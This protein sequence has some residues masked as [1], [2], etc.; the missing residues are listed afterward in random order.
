MKAFN[1]DYYL[2]EHFLDLKERYKINTVIETGTFEGDTTLWLS[3]NFFQVFTIENNRMYYDNAVQRF[4]GSNIQQ[5]FGDSAQQLI[6]ILAMLQEQFILFLDAHWGKN[7]LLGELKAVKHSGKKPIIIIHDFKVPDK[8]FG[9]D[10][11]KEQGIVYEWKYIE[12]AVHDI[13]GNNFERKFN[14]QAAGSRR[15]YVTI[16]P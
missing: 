7:P 14:W 1:G 13:Y 11:Y 6:P 2:A 9:Y 3:E 15:G 12:K 5:L 16:I 8:D 4:N 10:E